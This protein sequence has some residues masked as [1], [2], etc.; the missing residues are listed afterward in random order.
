[1]DGVNVYY[2]FIPDKSIYSNRKLPGFDAEKTETLLENTLGAGG[3][4]FVNL[5]DALDAGS[6]YRTD[7]H[8]NQTAL[9]GVVDALGAAMGFDADL[10]RYDEGYAGVFEGV[11]AGQLALP[12]GTDDLR[13]MQNPAIS[14]TRLNERTSEMEPVPVYDWDE[15]TALDPYSFFLSGAQPLIVLENGD[16]E[17]DRELYLFRD[18]FSSSL[19]PLLAGAYSK[20]VLIDLR[21]M[22]MRT[23]GRHVEFKQG[24]DALFLYSTLVLGN[25]EM[26]LVR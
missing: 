16:S 26:L 24:S 18:S 23:L 8:W 19:A 15:L 17:S 1:L 3:F 22:D 4:T 20:V 21:Y 6:Y 14:A 5:V 12:I 11:Y 2:S 7:L 25:P 9:A 13:F 10:S